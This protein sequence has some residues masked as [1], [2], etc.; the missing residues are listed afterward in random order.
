VCADGALSRSAKFCLVHL[1][2]SCE[3][4]T[5]VIWW[6]CCLIVKTRYCL[7]APSTSE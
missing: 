7:N 4:A 3:T 2:L 5:F 6:C 1:T